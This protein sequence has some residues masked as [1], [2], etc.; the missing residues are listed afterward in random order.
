MTVGHLD[1]GQ[2]PEGYTYHTVPGDNPFMQAAAS[3]A[4]TSTACRQHTGTAYVR[5]G[6]VLASGANVPESGWKGL[7]CP[8]TA[9]GCKSGTGYDLCPGCNATHGE[10]SAIAAAQ[11]ASVNL[12]GAEAYLDGHW[13]CCGP[14]WQAMIDAGITKVHLH[15]NARELYERPPL[16][17]ASD[18]IRSIPFRVVAGDSVPENRAA[19]ITKGLESVGIAVGNEE[20]P[21]AVT[22]TLTGDGA[23]VTRGG[24]KPLLV[25]DNPDDHFITDLAGRLYEWLI[26]K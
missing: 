12:E 17:L 26:T 19:V 10:R 22:I 4:A 1:P 2:A 6:R 8:R 18:A 24:A 3:A 14:C 21:N 11:A 20:T 15:E 23:T 7:F 13:W 16:R 9:L 25:G 5:D